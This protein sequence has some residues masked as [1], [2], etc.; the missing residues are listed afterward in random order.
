MSTITNNVRMGWG[1]LSVSLLCVMAGVLT[2]KAGTLK[3]VGASGGAWNTTAQNWQ[4]ENGDPSAWVDGSIAEFGDDGGASI[5]ASGTINLGGLKFQGTTKTTISGG[6]LNFA[7]QM[8]IDMDTYKGATISSALKFSNGFVANFV[9]PECAH[10]GFLTC[11]GYGQ[12]DVYT[13]GTNTLWRNC[14]LE[15]LEI[16]SLYFHKVGSGG[17]INSA[18]RANAYHPTW[19]NGE[20]TIQFQYPNGILG[21]IDWVT[22]KFEQVGDDVAVKGMRIRS[23]KFDVNGEQLKLGDDFVALE[24][25]DLLSGGVSKIY[26]GVHTSGWCVYGSE[27]H[28]EPKG[29]LEFSGGFAHTNATTVIGACIVSNGTWQITGNDGGKQQ[30]KFNTGDSLSGNGS[31]LIKH[32]GATSTVYFD[33]NFVN[34]LTGGLT[35]DGGRLSCHGST[36]K[37]TQACGPGGPVRVING[38]WCY[39]N[40]YAHET[41]GGSSDTGTTLYVGPNSK[42][43][44]SRSHRNI[45]WVRTI[46]DGGSLTADYES[47]LWPVS[48]EVFDLTLRN[49][50]QVTEAA[51]SIGCLCFGTS[52]KVTTVPRLTVD[53]ESEV[54]VAGRIRIMSDGNYGWNGN[55]QYT[56]FDTRQNLRLTGGIMTAFTNAPYYAVGRRLR[57]CGAAKLIF[58]YSQDDYP[59]NWQKEN[60]IEVCVDQGTLELCK[61][62]AIVSTQALS[63][64]GDGIVDS[65]AGVNTDVALLTVGGTNAIN[66]INFAAGSSL[67]CTNLAFAANA[68][69]LS[70]TGDV[71]EKTFR[72]GTTKFLTGAQ[73]S[74]VRINGHRAV[75]DPDGYL[76]RSGF[77]MSV[78]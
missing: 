7:A 22:L 14:R 5:A 51:T 13:G 41:L 71:G 1:K 35:I 21:N 20:L 72:V 16:K 78:R 44:S 50:A 6:I 43:T 38:G 23:L 37:G 27:I 58:D 47:S 77:A 10:P 62:N 32:T 46:I 34:S 49:G 59:A 74:K 25:A 45:R 33:N 30:H 8:P 29:T 4:D 75:Q 66:T 76:V 24:N 39:F 2:V 60:T 61:S 18:L 26:D 36:F 56:T 70:L 57:K 64:Y 55:S 54:T 15:D 11:R 48:Q 53:G 63:L 28:A 73:L 68:K 17:V 12:W 65:A 9:Q 40:T 3:W 19:N 42:F 69:G 67:T 31:L 52:G